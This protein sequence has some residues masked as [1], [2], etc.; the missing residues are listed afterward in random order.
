MRRERILT[1]FIFFLFILSFLKSDVNLPKKYKMWLE[2]DV[3]YI[4]S[5]KERKA[6]LKLKTDKER[7]LFIK[8]FWKV[9]DPTPGTPENE[10]KEEH[11][12]RLAIAERL[13]RDEGKP[14]W[15]TERGKFY[16]LLGKPQ[17]VER[18]DGMGRFYPVEVWYYQGDPSKGLPSQFRLVFYQDPGTHEYKLYYPGIDSPQKLLP[19]WGGDPFDRMKG[20]E[21]MKQIAPSLAD[22]LISMVPGEPAT[23]Y[24]SSRSSIIL[25]EI[26]RSPYEK[27]NTEYAERILKMKG[28]VEV[29]ESII[30]V[31]NQNEIKVFYHPFGFYTIHFAVSPEKFSITRFK[32]K[33]Y[34]PLE[35]YAKLMDSKGKTIL[36]NTQRMDLNF[37]P[38]QILRLKKSTVEIE[39]VIPAI[40]GKYSLLL[41]IRNRSSKEFSLVE[42]FIS[43]PPP[44]KLSLLSL[45]ISNFYKDSP[46]VLFIK[47]FLWGRKQF[48]PYAD[49]IYKPTDRIVVYGQV[50]LPS[51]HDVDK[52]SIEISVKDEDGKYQKT[53]LLKLS[54]PKTGIF[55]FLLGKL[56]PASYTLTASLHYKGTKIEER[57]VDFMITP[58]LYKPVP[59]MISK[60]IYHKDFPAL[61]TSLGRQWFAV[62]DYQ[63]ALFHYRKAIS[64]N[65]KRKDALEGAMKCLINLGKKDEAIRFFQDSPVK[66]TEMFFLAGKLLYEKEK[67]R[68]AEE[69]LR[70]GYA[71]NSVNLKIINLL[72]DVYMEL[73]MKE[74]AKLLLKRSL[75]IDPNQDVIKKKL[76][77]LN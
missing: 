61:Y 59:F 74:N 68:E 60:I 4:I 57:S 19:S 22:A 47:P 46:P 11:Y 23:N 62:G 44:D 56:P 13:F 15:R 6:F 25:S 38:S 73:G 2:R 77:M 48:Y 69:V 10:Y 34:A 21:V 41:I 8:M 9:R 45:G 42:R 24:S 75:E 3:R 63:K 54:D 7:E 39:G 18:Y 67:L 30:Y 43:I 26:V 76:E 35:I 36:E 27:V 17:V 29:E 71:T 52:I 50:N 5:D 16:I 53:Y 55:Y 49:S 51:R 72:A 31:P 33:Y 1:G 66:T 20:Y 58:L 64:L 40:P 37:S 70:Q 28:F 65:A 14:G 32:E 12:K